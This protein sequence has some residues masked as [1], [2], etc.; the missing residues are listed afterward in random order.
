MSAP[1]LA[2]ALAAPAATAAPLPT[3]AAFLAQPLH[4]CEQWVP[5]PHVDAPA[6]GLV[7]VLP[8]P[9]AVPCATGVRGPPLPND[10]STHQP[11]ALHPIDLPAFRVL[12]PAAD[13]ALASRFVDPTAFATEGEGPGHRWLAQANPSAHT[14]TVAVRVDTAHGP[15]DCVATS[16]T[17]VAEERLPLAVVQAWMVA[18]CAGLTVRGVDAGG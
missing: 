8:L 17:A 15:F 6:P 11:L 9:R 12:R 2:L 3:A 5:S 18:R 13:T 10:P 14:L 1:L 16:G 4:P 7:A